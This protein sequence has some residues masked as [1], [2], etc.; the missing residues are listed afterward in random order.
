M[1]GGFLSMHSNIIINHKIVDNK[2]MARNFQTYVDVLL[3]TT[4]DR[5]ES[6]IQPSQTYFQVF[7][8]AEL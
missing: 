4:F 5:Y 8:L 6:Q 2:N 1:S 7:E 3:P